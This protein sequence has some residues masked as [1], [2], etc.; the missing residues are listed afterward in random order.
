[1]KQTVL[2]I[3]T[4]LAFVSSSK[5]TIFVL[6]DSDQNKYYLSDSVK[7]AFKKDIITKTP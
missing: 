2:F 7:V 1:M 4:S 6:K 3:I 5:P